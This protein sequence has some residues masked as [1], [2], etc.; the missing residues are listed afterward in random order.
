MMKNIL[1]S[2]AATTAIVVATPASAQLW[3]DAGPVGVRVGPPPSWR[4]HH[5]PWVREYAYEVPACRVIRERIRQ[6]SGRLSVR[7]REVCD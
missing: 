7:E 3:F 1:F 6:P 2:L 5:R 4:W